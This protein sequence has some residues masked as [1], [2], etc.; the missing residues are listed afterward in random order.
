MSETLDENLVMKSIQKPSGY[1]GN[2][3]LYTCHLCGAVVKD[4]QTIKEHIRGKH[5]Q[6]HFYACEKCG[7][8]FRWRSG[9]KNHRVIGCGPPHIPKKLGPTKTTKS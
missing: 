2:Q 6:L 5:M 8:R 1:H 7:R 4:L 3:A 9:L